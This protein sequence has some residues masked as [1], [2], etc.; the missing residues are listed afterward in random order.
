MTALL[1]SGALWTLRERVALTEGTDPIAWLMLEF[2]SLLGESPVSNFQ[3]VIEQFDA[4]QANWLDGSGALNETSRDP[5]RPLEPLSMISA[6]PAIHADQLEGFKAH[7]TS[8][9]NSLRSQ[10]AAVQSTD[11][12]VYFGLSTDG[13]IAHV[14]FGTYLRGDGIQ[15]LPGHASEQ[16]K[17]K[18][19]PDSWGVLPFEDVCQ[20]LEDSRPLPHILIFRDIDTWHLWNNRSRRGNN[21]EKRIWVC[22]E[23]LELSLDR[24]NRLLEFRNIGRHSRFY[25]YGLPGMLTCWAFFENPSAPDAYA[26][27]ELIRDPGLT[28]LQ[29]ITEFLKIEQMTDDTD[30]KTSSLWTMLMIIEEQSSPPR[31]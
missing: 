14:Q 28:V 8:S 29:H 25:L 15:P 19:M 31:L 13:R 18:L 26:M 1:A 5:N 23:R 24:V 10:F 6:H 21:P 11:L 22:S 17:Q 27:I 2:S 30:T 3:L 20:L 12:G 4:L 7:A 9:I 16:L